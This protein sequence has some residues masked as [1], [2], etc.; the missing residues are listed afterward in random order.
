[1]HC[2]G[3]VNW[4]GCKD[5]RDHAAWASAPRGKWGQLTLLEKWMKNKK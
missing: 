3:G 4:V 2:V 5:S 1:M